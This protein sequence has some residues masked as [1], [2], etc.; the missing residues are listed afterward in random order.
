MHEWQRAFTAGR[1]SDNVS[2][3]DTVQKESGGEVEEGEGSEKKK[4]SNLTVKM[5]EGPL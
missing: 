5:G 2:H 3:H 4:K 1:Q